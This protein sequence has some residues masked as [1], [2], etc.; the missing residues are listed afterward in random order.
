LLIGGQE[1][2]IDT[3]R[4]SFFGDV[5]TDGTVN[6]LDVDPFVKLV[7]SG[8]YMLAADMDRDG[9][10]NGL[11]VDLFVEAVLGSVARSCGSGAQAAPFGSDRNPGQS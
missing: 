10:V 4:K 8:E 3:I 6:G 11:D 9:Q 7:T 1:L 5:N 2:G